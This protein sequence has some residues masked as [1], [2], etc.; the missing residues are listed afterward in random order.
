MKTALAILIAL[1]ATAH[2]ASWYLDNAAT[3]SNSGTSW[4]NA[5]PDPPSVVWGASGVTAG[6]TLFI[7]GGSTTK[8]YTNGFTVG[9]SGTS[10]N[11]IAIRVGQDAGHNGVVIFDGQQFGN[12][13]TNNAVFTVHGRNFLD[14]N[15]E[16]S[17]Q[18]NM[19]FLNWR[20]STNKNL[21]NVIY[22]DPSSDNRFTFLT[23]SNVNTPIFQSWCTNNVVAWCDLTAF[24][25]TC[26][27]FNNSRTNSL[28][29]WDSTLVFSNTFRCAFVW[30]P[31]GSGRNAPDGVQCGD[32]VSVFNNRFEIVWTATETNIANHNDYLQTGNGGWIKW[33]NNEHVD[34]QDSQ[35][36]PAHFGAASGFHDIRIYNNVFRFT[37][38]QLLYD[39]IPQCI[40]MYN[41]S[42]L[43]GYT[44][45]HI[46]NNLFID[47]TNATQAIYLAG[48]SGDAPGTNNIL[49][50]NIFV[51]VGMETG[52]IWQ[53]EKT[54]GAVQS[55]WVITNNIM[56]HPTPANA[57]VNYLDVNYTVATWKADFDPS[58]GTNLPAWV[59][60]TE[61]A[62]ANDFR[63]L[64]SDTAALDLGL[65]FIDT[66][67]TDHNGVT[68]PQGAAWDIGP[69]EFSSE[70]PFV[71]G[72]RRLGGI[73]LRRK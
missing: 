7:S 25:D 19:R 5:W 24:G 54:T 28:G 43:F 29:P 9:A 49:A 73:S 46:L 39:P 61:Y 52:A 36:S 58:T 23:I 50:N 40:R 65:A 59:S 33:Y 14:I 4:E 6:D 10:A 51:N 41:S 68:R 45:V 69:F 60:Y 16:V 13:C 55:A 70:L 17:G 62:E 18:K 32:S 3:G 22:G 42:G 66:F 64:S 35:C 2:G 56:Y 15:G 11:R 71:P 38:N 8:T 63:L 12:S 44:N 53:L 30:H 1:C 72:V 47:R 48:D 21:C 37:D 27:A 57:R 26:L 20:N 34:T 67:T 31:D